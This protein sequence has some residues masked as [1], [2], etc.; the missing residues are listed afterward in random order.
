MRRRIHFKISFTKYFSIFF[1]LFENL[2]DSRDLLSI[3]GDD[4]MFDI[5]FVDII[6]RISTLE[7]VL[8]HWVLCPFCPI[9]NILVHDFRNFCQVVRVFQKILQNLGHIL[10]QSFLLHVA[11]IFDNLTVIEIFLPLLLFQEIQVNL[12]K[13]EK[14]HRFHEVDSQSAIF[15]NQRSSEQTQN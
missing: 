15:R 11:E 13:P 12:I 10:L 9:I 1:F 7:V 2:R 14:D 3:F 5:D 8:S 6:E 4:P